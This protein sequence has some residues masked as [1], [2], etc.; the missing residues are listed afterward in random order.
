MHLNQ[1]DDESW[2]LDLNEPAAPQNVL[3]VIPAEM[4]EAELSSFLGI[5][6]SRTRTLARDGAL[7]KS[8]RGRFDVR[9]SVLSYTAR[10]RE[11]ADKEEARVQRERGELVEAAAV[12]REWASILRDLRNALLAVPSRCGAGLP[13]LTATDVATIDNEIR[14]A[15][16]GLGHAG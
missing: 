10:M 16:E 6:A 12:T 1:I 11:A 5:T 8:G 9:A 7:V 14:R 15:L 3:Q 13:H 4:T 2:I